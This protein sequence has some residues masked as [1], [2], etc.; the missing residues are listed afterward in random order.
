MFQMLTGDLPYG[1][2][3]PADLERLLRGELLVSVRARN[4]KVP[5]TINDIVMK[6]I[7]RP[8]SRR[9][10]AR[11]GPARRHP[12]CARQ[13]R[14]GAGATAP[15]HAA[16]KRLSSRVCRTSSRGSALA[17]HHPRGSAGTAARSCNARNGSLPF[18]G[19]SQ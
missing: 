16:G 11:V 1:T 10:I 12:L 6:A 17:I 9:A 7:R 19:E 2:P 8:T 5:R 15:T 13:G 18:C 4:P 14:A 3:S